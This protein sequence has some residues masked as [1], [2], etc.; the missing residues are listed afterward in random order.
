MYSIAQSI[1]AL[2]CDVVTRFIASSVTLQKSDP[3]P[4]MP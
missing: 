1:N 2:T 3:K 4:R